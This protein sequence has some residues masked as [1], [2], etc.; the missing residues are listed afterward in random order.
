MDKTLRTMDFN[1]YLASLIVVIFSMASFTVMASV[2]ASP[3]NI[4]QEPKINR[5]TDAGPLDITIS[6]TDDVGV[7]Y[8]SLIY[9]F[10]RVVPYFQLSENRAFKRLD[11]V[12]TQ[13]G[14]YKARIPNDQVVGNVLE[15]YIETADKAGNIAYKGSLDNPNVITFDPAA[16]NS[17]LIKTLPPETIDSVILAPVGQNP[18]TSHAAQAT[19]NDNPSNHKV[20]AWYE[21]RWIW[22]V[23]GGIVLGAV[24][25]SGGDDSNSS[26]GSVTITAPPL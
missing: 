3:P 22:A 24:L 6:V 20:T 18:G 26:T 5:A 2:D 21:N 19:G 9:R 14:D 15:Y 10:G 23:A 16:A 8:V 17:S 13:E 25:S 1:T 7:K 11:F 4:I 12:L